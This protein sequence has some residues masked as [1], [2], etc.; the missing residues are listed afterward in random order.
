MAWLE[1]V[2]VRLTCRPCVGYRAD[3]PAAVE[4]TALAALALAAHGRHEA[5]RPALEWL[6]RLQ[7]PDGT[8]GITA[9]LRQPH[10]PTGWALLAW[11]VVGGGEWLRGAIDRAAAWLLAFKGRPVPP[12]PQIG[13]DTTLQAWPWVDG[14][15]SWVEPTAINL[16][17]LKASG[18]GR[19]ARSRDAVR[20]LCD[21]AVPA[22]GWNY[23]SREV[24]GRAVAPHVQPTGLAL[25]A[26]AG[27]ESAAPQIASGIAHLNRSLSSEVT[28]A[29][30]CYALIGL[31]S[32]GREPRD[33]PVW[34]EA[35]ARR[36]LEQ[37]GAP[38]PLSLLALAASGRRC[39]WFGHPETL[40]PPKDR[41]YS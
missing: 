24:L 16:L 7:S 38:Y 23:G 25:A 27:E 26:L 5:A 12:S 13:H 8:L 17:A 2:L 34:L 35:A 20:L 39:P 1:E 37:G 14:T 40:V 6:A 41:E 15:H 19:H 21:R 30:L 22:G 18:M 4:P 32:H 33:A 9:T 10:W 31:S 29:S 28:T 3:G 36:T 11:S